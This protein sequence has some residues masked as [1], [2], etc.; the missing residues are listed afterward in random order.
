ML[1][2]CPQALNVATERS[3]RQILEVSIAKRITFSTVTAPWCLLPIQR[4]LVGVLQKL[5]FYKCPRRGFSVYEITY[6]GQEMPT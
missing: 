6:H 3:D 1:S 2:M 4:D 5:G